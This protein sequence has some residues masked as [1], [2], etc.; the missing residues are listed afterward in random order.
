MKIDKPRVN[1]RGHGPVAQQSANRPTLAQAVESSGGELFPAPRNT[2]T[3]T[4]ARGRQITIKKLGPLDNWRLLKVL[5]PD[6]SRNDAMYGYA[7]VVMAVTAIDGIPEAVATLLQLE[8]LIS[9][10]DED[11]MK[12]VAAGYRQHFATEAEAVEYE[13]STIKNSVGAE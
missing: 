13:P 12:A 10:L 5:G 11:G 2:V 3:I 6:H 1:I 8:A 4:D 7:V 9:R